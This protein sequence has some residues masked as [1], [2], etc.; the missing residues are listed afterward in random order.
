MSALRPNRRAF[1]RCRGVFP[2]KLQLLLFKDQSVAAS[3]RDQPKRVVALT[4]IGSESKLGFDGRSPLRAVMEERLRPPGCPDMDLKPASHH[5]I[6]QLEKA[7]EV[8]LPSPVRSDEDVERAK[9]DL[10]VPDRF[11]PRQPQAG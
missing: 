10:R 2:V 5:L 7:D 1:R 8:R 3:D 4:Q 11:P 6:H 9:F